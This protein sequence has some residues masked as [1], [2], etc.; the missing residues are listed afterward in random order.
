MS[1]EKAVEEAAREIVDRYG[2]DAL[3]IL[4]KRAEAAD[5]MDDA[6]ATKAWRDIVDSAERLLRKDS[7]GD[8]M[9]DA[10]ELRE[11]AQR[12]RELLRIAERQELRDQL[13]QWADDFDE[14]AEALERT[15]DYSTWHSER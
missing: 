10:E 9:T 4:R 11:K 1:A 13:R 3:P 6:L 5:E 15:A 14:E 7:G 12:C 8:A 2:A